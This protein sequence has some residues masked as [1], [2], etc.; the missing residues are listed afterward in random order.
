MMGLFA[1]LSINDTQR[2]SA[3]MLSVAIIIVLMRV[4]LLHVIMLHVIMLS[5]MAR[6]GAYLSGAVCGDNKMEATMTVSSLRLF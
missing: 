2:N 5:V 3:I 4:I 6:M 1:S